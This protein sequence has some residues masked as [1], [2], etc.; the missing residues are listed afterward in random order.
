MTTTLFASGTASV[1]FESGEPIGIAVISVI[2]LNDIG[3]SIPR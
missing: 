1:Q 3:G 2:D